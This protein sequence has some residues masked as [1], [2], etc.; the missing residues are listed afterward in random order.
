M[1]NQRLNSPG[2]TL[3]WIDVTTLATGLPLRIAVHELRG[4]RPGPTVGVTAAIHGDELAP[5]E[6]LR[7]LVATLDPAEMAGRLS[8]APVVNPLAFQAQTRHTPQD[9]QN[10]NRVF[11]GDPNGW[12][13][14]QLAD[15]FVLEFLPEIDVL[16]DLHAGGALPTVDYAYIN[17]D[18]ALSASLG[19]KVLYRGPGYPGTFTD[20]A[21]ARGIRCVVTELGGGL[22][23]DDHY[24]AQ[25][26]AGLTNALRHLGVIPGD[27]IQ[28]EDQLTI[29]NLAVIRPRQGGI[30]VPSVGA[31]LLGETV[32]DGTLL[33]TVYNPQTF[34]ELEAI[35]APYER[36]LMILARGT[37][38]R[39]EAGDYAYMV[40][41]A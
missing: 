22:V 11:P 7:R 1:S 16:F 37:V 25:T 14:E 21:M 24:I 17:N 3:R 31:D 29:D 5:V 2:R 34:E 39:V 18:E 23:R 13:T 41:S 6:A 38:T 20:V 12:L 10:L 19:T 26:V 30:L 36:T 27:V 15:V 28:R 8:I 9:M 35:H 33:G 40:S 32:A 4:A